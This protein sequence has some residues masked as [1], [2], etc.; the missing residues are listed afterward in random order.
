M[1]NPTINGRAG[2]GLIV[3]S[4]TAIIDALRDALAMFDKGHCIANFNWGASA[5]TAD[6]I[7]ELN[8]M[9][10]KLREALREARQ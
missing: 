5:L 10:S 9:P 1:T 6:N 4:R 8:E 7:R 2:S 3:T